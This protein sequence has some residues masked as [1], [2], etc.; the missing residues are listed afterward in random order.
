[1]HFTGSHCVPVSSVLSGISFLVHIYFAPVV[2][3][4]HDKK[5][6]V[7]HLGARSSGCKQIYGGLPVLTIFVTY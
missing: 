2:T 1:M 4:N 7:N 3:S 5:Y 6:E